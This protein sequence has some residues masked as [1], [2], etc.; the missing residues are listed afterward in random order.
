VYRFLLAPRWLALHLVVL[1]AVPAF[2]LLGKWQF[3]RYEMR[4][5]A[6]E[7]TQ[8]NLAA[9]AEPLERLSTVGGSVDAKLKYRAVT[10]GGR[11]DAG[12]EL[13]VRRRTLNGK[14]GYYVL[15]PLV[16][17]DGEAVLVV[18]GWVP[19]GPTAEAAPKVPP[20]STGEVTVTG[21]LMPA[22]TE[23]TTGISERSGLPQ[24][25]IML[26]DTAALGKRLPYRLHGGYVQLG[27]QNP[28][29]ANAPTPL[30]DP[31]PDGGGALNLAY[32]FQW[33]VFI[34]IAVGGWFVLIRREARDRRAAAE[35]ASTG[36]NAESP[37]KVTG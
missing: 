20:P 4:S 34:P 3:S 25:Q 12:N 30:P 17:R 10:V 18:R 32:S 36:K 23:E 21:R 11:F 8:A 29:A 19:M 37:E 7:R 31:E 14:V 26:I 1:L 5:A 15:T 28:P 33:W 16:V 35:A 9:P 6:Q 13:L 22:E 2:L 24:G 27:S